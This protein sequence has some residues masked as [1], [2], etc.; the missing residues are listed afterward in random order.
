[1]SVTGTPLD[2]PAEAK[3]CRSQCGGD[4]PGDAGGFL[5]AVPEPVDEG[6]HKNVGPSDVGEQVVPRDPVQTVLDA[7]RSVQLQVFAHLGSDGC[8]H[9]NGTAFVLSG[10]PVS[11]VEDAGAGA[12]LL[13][14]VAGHLHRLPQ[15]AWAGVPRLNRIRMSLDTTRRPERLRL[16]SVLR[17][18]GHHREQCGLSFVHGNLHAG[19]VLAGPDAASRSVVTDFSMCG[20]GC[21]DEDLATL[22]VHHAADG[23]WGEIWSAYQEVCGR[24]VD[25][26][27]VAW[28]GAR[29][30]RWALQDDQPAH[31]VKTATKA[32]PALLGFLTDAAV[33]DR[34]GHLPT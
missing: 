5:G 9:G 10:T 3:K 11:E 27:H 26:T 7:K 15:E 25:L 6:V 8:R 24:A 4:F 2:R 16:L 21:P 14:R 17:R 22:Y 31:L 12:R 23:H 20:V 28:H 29:Y 33:M 19:T 13:G 32:L 18:S 34:T 1:M 30:V